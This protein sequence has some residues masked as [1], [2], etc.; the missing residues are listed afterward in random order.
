MKKGP[1]SAV[2][3]YCTWCSGDNPREVKFCPVK[4]CP[5]YPFRSGKKPDGFQKSVLK[6]IKERCFDCSGFELREVKECKFKDCPLYPYRLGKNPKRKGIGFGNGKVC[7]SEKGTQKSAV[8]REIL[9]KVS[10]E[11]GD[12]EGI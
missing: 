9:E 12:F 10:S 3:E 5:L 2:K 11:R 6:A 1:L 4:D 7:G 8:S